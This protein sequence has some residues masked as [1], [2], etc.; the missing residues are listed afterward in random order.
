MIRVKLFLFNSQG[1]I[2]LPIDLKVKSQTNFTVI[3]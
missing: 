3:I 1:L 2:F